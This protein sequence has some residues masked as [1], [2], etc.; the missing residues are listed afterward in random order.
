[1]VVFETIIASVKGS[2]GGSKSIQ[3]I[4][5]KRNAGC[6]CIDIGT[7][8]SIY[9]TLHR[10]AGEAGGGGTSV[11]PHKTCIENGLCISI[12]QKIRCNVGSLVVFQ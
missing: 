6:T 10:K 4:T 3:C 2:V 9:I 11:D 5:I 1:M 12:D 8:I 7:V